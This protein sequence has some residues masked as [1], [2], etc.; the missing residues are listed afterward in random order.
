[1]VLISDG[2]YPSL[3]APNPN[4]R[5]VY[6]NLRPGLVNVTEILAALLSVVPVERAAVMAPDDGSQPVVQ[7]ELLAM[8]GPDIEVVRMARHDF[9]AATR[10]PDV[11]LVIVSGETRWWAN[12]LLTI[13]STPENAPDLNDRRDPRLVPVE[14]RDKLPSGAA[15]PKE[16]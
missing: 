1:L 8:I 9:Y 4:A 13:G 2:N 5:R 15:N 11:A 10:S 6:L 14:S 7:D 12:L 16:N 3:T